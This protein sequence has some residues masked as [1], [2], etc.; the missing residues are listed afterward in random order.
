MIEFDAKK[1]IDPFFRAAPEVSIGN[2]DSGV[3]LFGRDGPCGRVRRGFYSL[4]RGFIH[5]AWA[6][7]THPWS[8]LLAGE[9]RSDSSS[10][11]LPARSRG[12]FGG[13]R[14]IRGGHAL[15]RFASQSD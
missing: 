1:S 11:S 10:H 15:S 3:R 6:S 8:S 4:P 14:A 5:L 2:G 13:S 9:R 7:G 12:G